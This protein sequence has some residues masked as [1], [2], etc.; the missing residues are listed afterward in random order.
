MPARTKVDGRRSAGARQDGAEAPGEPA[1]AD[2][3][4]E[5]FDAAVGQLVGAPRGEGAAAA[6]QAP[7]LGRVQAQVA[8]GQQAQLVHLRRQSGPQV[9]RIGV[10]NRVFAASIRQQRSR[11]LA[12]TVTR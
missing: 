10:S 3:V 6:G 2:G 8:D 7:E 9:S 11:A 1:A 5:G 4:H 12:A